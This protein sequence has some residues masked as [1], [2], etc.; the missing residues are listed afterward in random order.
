MVKNN[1]KDLIKSIS[2][3]L[4]DVDSDLLLSQL[5]TKHLN[6]KNLLITTEMII[7]NRIG[8]IRL[9]KKFKDLK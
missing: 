6:G 7:D 9:A 1:F 2:E 3:H 8:E 4:Q 5:K